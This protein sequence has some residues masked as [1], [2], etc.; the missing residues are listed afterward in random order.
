MRLFILKLPFTKFINE[1]LI[2]YDISVCEICTVFFATLKNLIR[3]KSF[4][5]FQWTSS[6]VFII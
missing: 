2:N 3:F 1:V 4:L 6:V 5:Q